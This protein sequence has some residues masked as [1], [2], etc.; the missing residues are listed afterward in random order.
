MKKVVK[1]AQE[2]ELL[3]Q[4]R[5]ENPDDNWK[6]DFKPNNPDG[7][8]QV[9]QQLIDD[10]KGL[11]AYCEIDLKPG[12]GK[13]TDDFRVEHFHPENPHNPPPNHALDWSNMLGCCSGGNA[14]Y[15]TDSEERFTSPD[16]SCDVPKGSKNLTGSILNPVTDIPAYPR[17][18]KYKEQGEDA[19]MIEIDQQ[20]CPEHLQQ[21]AEQ[22]L[23]EL[24][25]NAKRVK[26]FRSAV[27]DKLREALELNIQ[28]GMTDEEA[29]QDLAELYF[30]DQSDRHWPAFFT[31]IRWYLADMAEERLQEIGYNG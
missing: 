10:Q 7:Y 6:K 16:H 14:K 2:P 17:L 4:Y 19:G 21:Q 28:S 3:A 22:S 11:C 8:K 23:A 24:N 29:L 25:L 5:Q 15:V 13:G 27:I 1:S 31:T 12:H 30:T 18:F 9:K 20:L 26:R